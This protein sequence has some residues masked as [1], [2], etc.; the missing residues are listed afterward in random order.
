LAQPPGVFGTQVNALFYLG[1]S[2]VGAATL[3]DVRLQA[4]TAQ[5]PEFNQDWTL[6]IYDAPNFTTGTATALKVYDDSTRDEQEDI[7]SHALFM[8]SYWL[9]SH[10]VTL[11]GW[12]RDHSDTFT[13]LTPERNLLTGEIDGIDSLTMQ[14]ASTQEEDSLTYSIVAKFPEDLLF[15][16]PLESEL[17]FFW[18]SSENFDPVGQRRNVYNE[19][20]GSPKGETEE[21]GFSLTMLDGKIDLRVTHFETKVVNADVGG[22]QNPYSYINAL[23]NRMVGAGLSNYTPQ[24]PSTSPTDTDGFEWSNGPNTFQTFEEVAR[25]FYEAIPQDLQD[26]IGPEYNFNPRFIEFNGEV[27]W[28]GDQITNL[29]SLSDVV[30]EGYEIELVYNPTRNW[31]IA[32]NAAQAKAVRANIASLELQFVDEFLANVAEVRDGELFNFVRNP[33]SNYEPWLEQY[34]SETIYGLRAEAAQSGSATPEIREWRANLVTSYKFDDGFLEGFRIGGAIRWQDK[35]AAGYPS[36][37]DENNLLV[38][39]LDNPW[40]A[41]DT[42]YVDANLGYNRDIR[43]FGKDVTWNINLNI[44]NIFGGDDLIPIKINPDGSYGTVRIPPE[45]TWSLATSINW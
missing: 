31:R 19:E 17:R 23:I 1:D 11:V 42:T 28:E 41:P 2:Q 22:I 21:Y 13:S 30:S 43:L 6:R 40:Y 34:R 14:P 16:L 39:D 45:R 35:A 26:R 3:D 24:D 12:R 36:L 37:R 25:A 44:R 7:E 8:N 29:V 32:I 4:I 15:D 9:D 18:N 20:V 5:R 10:I 38:A 27:S 33:G